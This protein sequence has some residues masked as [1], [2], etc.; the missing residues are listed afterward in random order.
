MENQKGFCL[1]GW[2]AVCLLILGLLAERFL[3]L[4]IRIFWPPCL[5][6]LFT[7]YYC[8]GCGGT[9]AAA[10]LVHGRLLQ[11]FVYHPVVPYGA[12]LLFWLLMNN[13]AALFFKKGQ[14]K[15]FRK[16]HLVLLLLLTALHFA[17]V[18]WCKWKLG[19]DILA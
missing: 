16:R 19:I 15:S 6:H 1:L 4:R 7:G 5:F 2:C 11:S 10:A 8:P 14:P 18:N 9:R 12:G 17:G 3:G 13:T